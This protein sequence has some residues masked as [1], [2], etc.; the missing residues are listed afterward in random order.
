VIRFHLDENVNHAI[1]NGL[2]ERGVDVTTSTD[3]QLIAA[4]DE[5]QLFFATRDGRVLFTHEPIFLTRSS[6]RNRTLASSIHKRIGIP[7]ETSSGIWLLWLRF[8]KK[9][10]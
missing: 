2:R 3:A 4:A 6:P 7:L 10:R 9:M 5:D 8:W 1:A